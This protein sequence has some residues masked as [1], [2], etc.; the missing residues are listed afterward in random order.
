MEFN[1]KG[2]DISN[3][4]NLSD[5][6]TLTNNGVE[7]LYLKAT[8]G[9]TF[10]DSTSI[11]RYSQAKDLGMKVGFYHFLVSTSSPEAQ[12]ES[13]W[14][15]V[16][17][18]NCDLKY[19]VDVEKDWNGMS[20]A[21]IDFINHWNEISGGKELIIYTYSGFMCNF[22]QS[23]IDVIKDMP[24]WIANYRRDYEGVNTGFFTNICGW[25]YSENGNIGSFTGDCNWFNE[26]C[27]LSQGEWLKGKSEGNENKW[28]YRHT[29][30]SYT[31]NN[32]EHV[33][34]EWFYFD[35]DGWAV[36]GWL[37]S[38]YSGKWYYFYTDT[39]T[40]AHDTTIEGKYVLGSDGAM[41][42]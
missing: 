42:E 12:A 4:N 37:K 33:N 31:I 20:N 17:D 40:M 39:C 7:C 6:S 15:Y 9:A 2:V 5:L 27:L 29:D 36:T 1:I 38:P 13:F 30:G 24:C 16:K 22:T 3:N 34:N 8:E 25:Q 26:K 14:N 19:C 11:N 35:N 10:K 18:F 41:I 32:W 23:A 28:W 21:T